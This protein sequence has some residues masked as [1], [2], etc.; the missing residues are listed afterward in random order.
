[1]HGHVT[2]WCYSPNVGAWIAL[3]LVSR[4][5]ERH[6]EKVWAV[7]PLA[8]EKVQVTIQAPVFIDPAGERLRG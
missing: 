6:G 3:A 1:M 7:S 4:G 8:N 5:R 2:S